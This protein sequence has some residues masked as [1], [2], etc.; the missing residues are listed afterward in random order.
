MNCWHSAWFDHLSEETE[1]S[2]VYPAIYGT[3]LA[4]LHHRVQFPWILQHTVVY[5][6]FL[7]YGLAQ[8]HVFYISLQCFMRLSMQHRH[9]RLKGLP[10]LG[11][12]RGHS[13][14]IILLLRNRSHFFPTL[15]TES[16]TTPIELQ[17]SDVL[18]HGTTEPN[19]FVN[20]GAGHHSVLI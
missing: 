14:A 13:P 8:L 18:V 10:Y 9:T 4:L 6:Y 1:R 3:D 7:S 12:E 5:V 11:I 19:T 15:P 20:G 17:P 16:A 2:H